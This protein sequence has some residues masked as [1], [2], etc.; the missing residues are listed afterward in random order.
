MKL[1]N[2]KPLKSIASLQK[3]Q[4]EKRVR[5]SNPL[6]ELDV[7]LYSSNLCLY[8]SR[9]LHNEINVKNRDIII[10]MINIELCKLSRLF[11]KRDFLIESD[12]TKKNTKEF[13]KKVGLKTNN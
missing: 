7:I 8:A 5:K 1:N 4:K 13:F 6:N 11:S 3:L 12:Y 9:I 10:S 2:I